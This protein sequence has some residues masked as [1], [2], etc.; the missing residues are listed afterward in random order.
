VR[1]PRTLCLLAD[2]HCAAE[3]SLR[4]LRSG[5]AICP[6]GCTDLSRINGRNKMA[7]MAA[8]PLPSPPLA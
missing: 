8:P 7:V 6:E 3:R 1:P 5:R 4:K 2:A